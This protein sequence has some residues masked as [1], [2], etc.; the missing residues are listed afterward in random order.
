MAA[1]RND[2]PLGFAMSLAQNTPALEQFGTLSQEEQSRWI[3]RAHSVRSKLE[4]EQLIS[5]LSGQ[6]G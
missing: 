3:A 2:L 5:Q 1:Q 6:R 4:M